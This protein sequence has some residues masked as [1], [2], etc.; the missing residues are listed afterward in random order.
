SLGVDGELDTQKADVSVTAQ[1]LDFN[2]TTLAVELAELVAKVDAALPGVGQVN[3]SVAAPALQLT[4]KTASGQSFTLDATLTQ[5]EGR[6]VVSQVVLNNLKGNLQQNITGDLAV[7]VDLDEN[8][9]QVKFDLA[10]PLNV[11]VGKQLVALSQF[12]GGLDVT[13]AAL[14]KG[15]AVMPLN[16]SLRADV[17]GQTADLQLA[18][19]FESTQFDL[20]AGVK[21]FASPFITAALKADKLD[22]DALLPPKKESD[23]PAKDGQSQPIDDIPVDLSP[24]KA[25]NADA[26]VKIGHLKASGINVRNIDL[27]AVSRGGKLTVNPM[28]ANLYEGSSQGSIVADANNNLVTIKQNLS[29]VQIEP[30]LKDLLSKDMAAGKG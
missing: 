20:K 24:L 29:D 18:S 22:I 10:S 3:A 19:N 9:R 23:A 27:R 5:P 13:D 1:Q 28:S 14:P 8:A 15:K 16:G 4:E 26:T 11:D 30:L 21:D 17:K 12:K 6:K 25:V 2:P 7:K